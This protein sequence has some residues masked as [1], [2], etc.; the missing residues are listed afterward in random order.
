METWPQSLRTVV[1]MMLT[2]RFAMWIGWGAD[3]PSST[4]TR[5]GAT[6]SARSIRG[7]SAGRRA[8]CGRRS[9]TTSGRASTHVLRH[10]RGDL[11]RS[12]APLPR[13]QR[14]PGGD[15][16]HVLVQPAAPTTTG[17]IARAC[18][19]SSP[20]RPSASSA[21]GARA[22][23][24][25]SPPALAAATRRGG[26]ARGDGACLGANR[27]TSRSRS[28]TSSTTDGG[29]RARSPRARDRGG[30]AARAADD[31]AADADASAVAAASAVLASA[32]RRGRSTLATRFAVAAH[33][34][35]GRAADARASLVPI[36][37]PGQAAA[38]GL[39][40]AGAQ[41]ATARSTTRTAASSS[42][43]SG[44]SPPASPT[45][46]PTRPSGGAPRRS[47]SSTARRPR[48]S[49]T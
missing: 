12:A 15:L 8:R 33:R 4:T 28:S 26:R 32:R 29:P 38:G 21:S 14:L 44:R 22:R 6:R 42:S 9:G 40:V 27:A 7:R 10:R 46:A 24:A 2:S 23:C 11:G 35:V 48:S 5:T 47:P 36:A 39:F 13:A 31:R 30:H 1:G 41:S 20:R 19:A 17:A 25:T 34:R 45:R 18:S 43:S 49:R 3:L 37:Q 16:P